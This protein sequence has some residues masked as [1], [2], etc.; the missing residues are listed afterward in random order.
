MNQSQ[1]PIS[2]LSGSHSSTLL[3]GV[4]LRPQDWPALLLLVALGEAMLGS[5]GAGVRRTQ[6][7]GEAQQEPLASV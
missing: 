2:V 4:G 5:Q 1:T 7:E 6:V 3:G